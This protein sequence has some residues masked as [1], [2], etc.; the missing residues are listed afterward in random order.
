MRTL[1]FLLLLANVAYFAFDAYSD[2]LFPGESQL[3]QQQINPE[4]IKLLAT[5]DVSRPARRG[6]GACVEWGGF[7][8][9]D[10]ARAEE[11]LAPLA[12]GA[13]LAQRRVE[14]TASWWVYFPPQGSRQ[15]ANVKTAEL[16]RLGIEDFFIVQDDP[17]YRYAVSLGIFRTPE[18]ANNYLEQLRAKGVRTAQ[19]GARETQPPKTWFQVRDPPDTV[20]AKLNELRQGFPGSEVR[21]C[22]PDEKKG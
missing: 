8:D 3:L 13:R 21:D 11:A 5:A 16:K 1:F 19:A 15:A 14:D 6:K 18:A 22:A 9:A 20:A 7:V 4:T 17:K 10:A 2:I 12:L